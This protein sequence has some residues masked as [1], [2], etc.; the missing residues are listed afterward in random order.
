MFARI[1]GLMTILIYIKGGASL[2]LL[3]SDSGKKSLFIKLLPIGIFRTILRGGSVRGE[4]IFPVFGRTKR[5]FCPMGSIVFLWFR[6]AMAG[7]GRPDGGMIILLVV[8]HRFR[9]VRRI[10]PGIVQSGFIIFCCGGRRREILLGAMYRMFCTIAGCMRSMG[11]RG[12]DSFGEIKFFLPELTGGGSRLGFYPCGR[13][14]MATVVIGGLLSRSQIM[15][16]LS[17]RW[18]RRMEL[19]LRGRC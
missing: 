10:F 14:H 7:D 19:H 16:K 5:F 12:V 3:I 11:C 6:P 9:G 4:I 2:L 8:L 15:E 18:F 17:G 13:R 1:S